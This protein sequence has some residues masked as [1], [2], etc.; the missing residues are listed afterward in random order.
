MNKKIISMIGVVLLIIC[1]SAVCLSFG[2][3][4]LSFN[5]MPGT[6]IKN[7]TLEKIEER[8]TNINNSGAFGFNFNNIIKANE[9]TTYTVKHYK[10]KT[11]GETYAEP[12]VE[13]KEGI[14][15]TMVLAETKNYEGFSAP[16]TQSV[17]IEA[18]GS[19]E[20]EYY[21]T[22]NKYKLELNSNAGIEKVEGAGEYYYG[23]IVP[24]SAQAVDGYSFSYWTDYQGRMWT[25]REAYVKMA[26]RDMEFSANARP[27]KN[28]Q[29]TVEHYKMN[30]DGTTDSEPFFVE[31]K[32]GKTDEMV[33]PEVKIYKGFTSP[34][35]QTVK[36][37]ADGSTVV[38]YYYT[39]N[40]YKLELIAGTGI[41]EVKGTGE[42]YY[43]QE[44]E[45]SA[46]PSEGFEFDKWVY[47]IGR[48]C[49]DATVKVK[50]GTR[51]VM[52]VA[53]AKAKE[54][55][56]YTVK[57]YKMN[58]DG[59]TFG[60]PE[61]ETK[62]GTENKDVTPEVK[63][64]EGFTS[65]ELKTVTISPN[66]NTVVEYYYTRNKYKLE[67]KANE[68]IAEVK[69]SGEYY[70]E[71]EV[72]IS[73]KVKEG[74]IFDCWKDANG[75]NSKNIN[76][77]VKIGAKDAVIEANAVIDKS[78]TYKI[79]YDANGGTAVAEQT[80]SFGDKIIKPKDPTRNGYKFVGWYVNLT[81][82]EA[83]DFDKATATQ[84]I[85]LHAKWEA[86]KYTVKFN[87]NGGQ[88]TMADQQFTYDQEGTLNANSFTRE[89]YTFAGWSETAN[90]TVQYGN[91]A[92][93]KNLAEGGNKTLY[94][95]WTPIPKY[96]ITYDSKG[97]T[98]VDKQEVISGA[99][100]TMP[101]AP[102]LKG[103]TFKGW[104]IDAEYK[105]TFD[106]NTAITKNITLYAK[107]EA[108]K[109][110]VKFNANGGQGTMA[111]QQF[112]YDQEG[113]LNANSFTREGY[114]FAGWSETANG[115]VQYGNGA[116]VKNLAESGS[117]ALYAVW[118]QN[119]KYTITFNA[120]NGT[121]A[122]AE[123][124]ID[125]N[126]EVKLNKNTFKEEFTITYNY[127]NNDKKIETEKVNSKFLGWST[128]KDGEVKY[129]DEAN[130]KADDNSKEDSINLYA[131]W[132][133][134][135]ITLRKVDN[136]TNTK[137]LG[138]STS[139]K[140]ENIISENTTYTVVGNITLTAIWEQIVPQEAP[141]IESISFVVKDEQGQTHREEAIVGDEVFFVK[142][143]EKYEIDLASIMIKTNTPVR[144]NDK[145]VSSKGYVDITSEVYDKEGRSGCLKLMG[146]NALLVNSKDGI[147]WESTDSELYITLD[148]LNTLLDNQNL[149]VAKGFAKTDDG[150]ETPHYISNMEQFQTG[151]TYLYFYK[152]DAKKVK[153]ELKNGE[154][155][156]YTT[157]I[158]QGGVLPENIGKVEKDF[159][160]WYTDAAYTKKFDFSKPVN[161]D[162]ILYAKYKE[163][164]K[165][166]YTVTYDSKGGTAVAEQKI[167]SGE[168][169][170]APT[171]PTRKGYTFNGW[172]SDAEYKTKFD[173]NTA[174]TKN[175]TLY[176]KWEA[177]KYTI[178]FDANGGTGKMEDQQFAYDQEGNL[179]N[180]T[181]TR[182]GYTFAGWGE[183]KEAQTAKYANGEKVKNL[184]ESGNKTLYAVWTQ[185]QNYTVKFDSK[186][187][188]SVT[189]Q[190]VASGAKA[191][192]P[193]APT[194]KGYTFKGWYKDN[195]YKEE[196][197]FDTPV[198]QNLTLY[199]KWEANKYTIKFDS[200]GGTGTMEPQQFTYDQEGKLNNNS[201]TREGYTFAGW[202]ETTNG[203]V[204]YVNGAKVTNLAESGNKILYAVWT[205]NRKYTII[206]NANNGTNTTTQQVIDYDKGVT[207]NK[208][209]FKEE[210]TVTYNHN[211]TT[212]NK[213]EKVTVSS[214]FLGWS[215]EVNG[216]VKYTDQ[217]RVR[218]VDMNNGDSITLYA[219]WQ[220]PTIT[221]QKLN[222]TEKY[223]FLGWSKTNNKN[224][225]ISENTTYTVVGNVTLT[226]IWE[227]IK[228]PDNPPTPIEPEIIEISFNV[229]TADGQTV[230]GEVCN[231][232]EVF[233]V[234]LP[235]GCSIDIS[236]I[237][238][239]TNTPVKL[240]SE[241]KATKQTD[242][243]V[244][245]CSEDG[246]K[247]SLS[248]M[249][250][251]VMKIHS[252]D[253]TTWISETG[254][255]GQYIDLSLLKM[256]LKMKP[257]AS[258][259]IVEGFG[260]TDD[261]KKT[262]RY[263]SA[264]K[265]DHAGNVYI[266]F[267]KTGTSTVNIEWHNNGETIK[268]TIPKGGLLPE[269]IGVEK[270]GFEGWYTDEACTTKFDFKKTITSNT[271]LYAKYNN[272]K[273][274]NAI[275]Y[276]GVKMIGLF[277]QYSN[278]D[279]K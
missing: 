6:N 71:T 123:Q 50:I 111:D 57:H 263:D 259:G 90:G 239:K 175:I 210:F 246:R 31:H 237:Q 21:Y 146:F 69:G 153:I 167:T 223:K 245:D 63:Q 276:A 248:V 36:V 59:K 170:T 47:D 51:N 155:N 191:T 154:N 201:F 188:T 264:I 254:D 265:T 277:N 125:F 110:T 120:N 160:G 38:K 23:Q 136:T 147:T 93:V 162:T 48:T 233:Y 10:M 134:P 218:A 156:S 182:T 12:E 117:K 250:M 8:T 92:K 204:K 79:T 118:T 14:V 262:P 138:W 195:N 44:V 20:I 126:K 37:N 143:P 83:F 243:A 258:L 77:K 97:G 257:N 247:A 172:Y 206:F 129:K 87:A 174:I 140:K 34:E 72:E 240:N 225:I 158:P 271:V 124:V 219:K 151:D 227:E 89:G 130:I 70:Y 232:D 141:K 61:V 99:K 133:K 78:I 88:G 221:L 275:A 238:L 100:A 66:G 95:V 42:Y 209:T 74:Y 25:D 131:K 105:T 267:Y 164:E 244:T 145:A 121:D 53:N 194:R 253:G 86:N 132:E 185:N 179:N 119:R 214:T 139:D 5:S 266:Y 80:V 81:D 84:N 18:D 211:N 234:K 85:T 106:F 24:I 112:T 256:A 91:G 260:I 149:G 171:A 73:A 49:E 163:P 13:T 3:E 65:P 30:V 249:N 224:D 228:Q 108:N 104:Y 27:D 52:M 144:L 200:N 183:T 40:K 242:I 76:A 15:G 9:T 193:T 26:N 213:T 56:S 101:T 64:Y 176:A 169:T 236:S 1:S 212:D 268:N 75:G 203:T 181:F 2:I 43:E 62:K 152:E 39:R 166:I 127:N 16:K 187:G 7:E 205:Q 199:A 109:Y 190:K 157:T 261:G 114:T 196:F 235:N 197:K 103:Y 278:I 41:E 107:W 215:T 226:A 165:E 82:K 168:K 178:K 4:S 231:G 208:N 189:E 192:T 29:Y 241:A 115:T 274:A 96:T 54:E 173:F 55:V 128:E 98:A 102:T 19:T 32:T 229:K 272:S 11:D 186:G 142:F 177:N 216:E 94:A 60:T 180:N 270:E 28:V 122:K 58:L 252:T 150:Q 116:K 45:I 230:R 251:D 22:R 17:K 68:G 137:F 113:T 217:E 220:K 269:R 148:M 202:S 184:A 35:T 159:E 222:D 161:N 207:L 46:K 198:T 67:L 135:T 273:K 33:T 255:E 279:V